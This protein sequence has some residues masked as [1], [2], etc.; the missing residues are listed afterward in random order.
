MAYNKRAIVILVST[1]LILVAISFYPSLQNG[2]T[3]WD[4]DKYFLENPNVLTLSMDNTVRIFTTR[5]DG[6]WYTPLVTCS[7]ALEK[8]I[9]GFNPRVLHGTNLVLH[10]ANCVLVFWC[11]LLLSGNPFVAFLTALFFG[12]HPQHVESVAWLTERNNLMYS[13]FFL[14][15]LIS[16]IYREENKERKFYYLSLVFYI[17]SLLSK[18]SAATLPAVLILY[19]FFFHRRLDRMSILEKMPFLLLSFLG[20]FIRLTYEPPSILRHSVE[21]SRN[22]LIGSFAIVQDISRML[23][24]RDL[25]FFY[26]YPEAL[27]GHL[28]PEVFISFGIMLIFVTGSVCVA[29]YSRDAAFGAFFFLVNILPTSQIIPISILTLTADRFTYLSSMG[30]FYSL[31]IMCVWLATR[32]RG[33]LIVVTVLLLTTAFFSCTTW[34]LCGIW[35]DSLTLWNFLARR[36][37][38]YAF[39]YLQRGHAYSRMGLLKRAVED[40][41]HALALARNDKEISALACFNRGNIRALQGD[42]Q[43]ALGDFTSTITLQPEYGKAYFCRGVTFFQLKEND[44]ALTDFREALKWNAFPD[45]A[46]YYG[47][48]INMERKEPEKALE[49]LNRA[50]E[51]HPGLKDACMRRGVLLMEKNA[52]REAVSNFTRVLDQEP[53]NREAL[54]NRGLCFAKAGLSTESIK[55]FSTLLASWPDCKEALYSRGVIYLGVKDYERASRDLGEYSRLGGQVDRGIQRELERGLEGKK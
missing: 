46:L 16:Y 19:D 2:F 33:K 42:Y 4:D 3:N 47:G 35:K 15:S 13:F 23:F 49:C 10:E 44:K 26:P 41:D 40:Y 7:F 39:V 24:P 17:F 37:P 48:V 36:E 52:Y 25:S 51:L 32:R 21:L 30:F 55:D 50:L 31:S 29:R 11:A 1:I 38:D 28:P 14:L 9:F 43:G 22:I 18:E 12:I 54:Y 5:Q 6:C 27:K 20:V 45:Q 53:L 34:H 8:S